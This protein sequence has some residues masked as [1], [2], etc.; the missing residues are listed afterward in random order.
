MAD[1]M[2][3]DPPRLVTGGIDTHKDIHVAAVTDHL[4]T[5]R[6]T[7]RFPTTSIGYQA[8]TRWLASHGVIDRIGVE[9]C[10]SWGAGVARHLTT[11][12]HTVVEINRPNRQARYTQGKSDP[13]DAINAARAALA[14]LD[15]GTP[16]T[17]AGPVEAIRQL[18]GCRRS[19]VQARTATIN[20]IRSVLDT[21]PDHIRDRY[22]NLSLMRLIKAITR[23]RPDTDRTADPA[24]ATMIALKTLGKRWLTL[25]DE[26]NTVDELLD[27][28]VADVA[29]SLVSLSCVGT[30]TAAALLV[31]AGDN[32][33]RLRSE[34]SFAALCGTNPLPASSG[35]TVR[36]RLNRGG[37]RDANNALWRIVMSRMA[38]DTRTRDYVTRR[39]T[40]G[41]S[42]REIIR[43][44]KRY[45]AREVF[46]AITTDLNNT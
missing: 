39:T 15:A 33:H 38:H 43:C 9:G 31:A 27:S 20:Q 36:H 40:E 24:T 3:A 12:G 25:T 44:L 42:K 7:R 26:I 28:L 14:G 2:I 23:T 11:A 41:L 32:P 4:G 34:A 17:G 35:K 19:A 22:R 8:L 6:G 29:P 18:R 5:C 13:L 1:A 45:V 30:N 16:K 10:G 21:A 37:D 46:S